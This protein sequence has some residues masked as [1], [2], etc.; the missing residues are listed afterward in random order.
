MP[1]ELP[2]TYPYAREAAGALRCAVTN[3]QVTHSDLA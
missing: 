3:D 2:K 1:R